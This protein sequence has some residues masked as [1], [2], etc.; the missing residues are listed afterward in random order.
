VTIEIQSAATSEPTDTPE[1]TETA[2]PAP[3]IDDFEV[4]PTEIA[5]GQCVEVSWSAS[6]GTF[7]V[8][9]LRDDDYIWENAPVTGSLQDCPDKAGDYRYRV[10]AWNEVDD[11]VREDQNVT[12]TE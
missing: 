11:R 3:V 2:V 6:G 12:V 1:P 10:V 9:I 4:T 7:W 8:N 5:V